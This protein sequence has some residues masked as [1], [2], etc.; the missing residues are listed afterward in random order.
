ME[1]YSV[2]GICLTCSSK[3]MGLKGRFEVNISSLGGNSVEV[4][5]G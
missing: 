5:G 4:V 2:A 1:R 3:A